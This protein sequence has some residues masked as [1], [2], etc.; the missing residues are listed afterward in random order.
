MTPANRPLPSPR[1]LLIVVVLA[2][3]VGIGLGFVA[4]GPNV[5]DADLEL[6]TSLQQAQGGA[7]RWLADFGNVLGSTAW[8]A[9]A[10]GV[11]LVAAAALR[12]WDEVWFLAILLVL[13]LLATQIKPL[14]ESP[15]PTDDLVTIVGDWHGSG[16][17]SGHALTASTMGLGLAV[18]AWR[19]VPSRRA[20]WLIIAVLAALVLIVGWARI[21]S[22]AHWTSD[23]V[24]GYAFGTAIVALTTLVTG[25]RAELTRA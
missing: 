25:R 24:G 9:V 5:L 14:F 19:R 20:A 6:T 16:Y 2:L 15:R 17:P 1:A 10:I 18:I 4:Y 23:V 12:A 8:A 11:G 22:G 13:R 7:V 3:A 21:W